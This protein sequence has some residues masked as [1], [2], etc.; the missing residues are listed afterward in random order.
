LDTKTNF[1]VTT[2][3]PS[4]DDSDSDSFYDLCPLPLRTIS[5]NTPAECIHAELKHIPLLIPKKVTPMVIR[6]WEMACEDFYS[7]NKKL[8]EEDRVAAVLPSLK[9][10]HAR[11]WVAMHHMELIALPFASFMKDLCKEFL[12]DGWDDE[13]HAHICNSCLKP[14]DSFM[15]W[16]NN[17]HH[18]NIIL[19]GTNYHFSEDAL[20]FQLDSLLNVDLHTHC[21]NRKVKELVESVVNT[22]EEQTGEA[23]LAKW[24]SKIHKLA[25]EHSHDM[26]HYLEASKDFQHAGKCQALAPNSCLTNTMSTKPYSSMTAMSVPQTKLPHLTDNK[27]ALLHKHQGCMKC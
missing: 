27:W 7:V 5:A 16:V 19:C 10:M 23:C 11:D 3:E 1:S 22:A 17:I 6:Q 14:S 9:D 8:E 26:K 2:V 21:K 18:L 12:S 24:I 20:C 4:I 25:E 15:K 13:L